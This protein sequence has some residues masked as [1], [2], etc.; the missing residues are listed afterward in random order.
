MYTKHEGKLTVNRLFWR[1]DLHR[2]EANATTEVFSA[3]PTALRNSA[4]QA[5]VALKLQ[6]IANMLFA[7]RAS[8]ILQS[9]F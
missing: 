2:L 6:Y 5:F 1:S 9:R 3:A 7:R 8:S 4:V